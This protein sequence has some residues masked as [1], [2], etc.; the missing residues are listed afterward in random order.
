MQVP[1]TP[2]RERESDPFCGP[3]QSPIES[4]PNIFT[5]GSNIAV[6]PYK[7]R[8]S[9]P[10][11]W[12]EAS[13]PKAKAPRRSVKNELSPRSEDVKNAVHES[14][15]IVHAN[16][17]HRIEE[18]M[19]GMVETRPPLA[20]RRSAPHLLL[21]GINLNMRS[22]SLRVTKLRDLL[23]LVINE[24]LHVGG[25]PDFTLSEV[26]ELGER[27][28]V[29][30]RSSNGEIFS[31]TIVWSVD[32]ALPETLL[33]DDK[34]LAKLIS[35][36]F[37]NAVKFTNS[38]MITV[39]AKVG[40]NVG[41]VFITV[42][43]T[44]PGIPEAFLPKLFTPFAREDASI[45][46]SKD[47][48]GLGLLVAKGL[49]RKMGGDLICVRSS[50]SGPDHGSEF[51]ISIPVT[52]SKL[53]N[54]PVA[55]TASIPTPPDGG[56]PSRLSTTSTS[57]SSGLEQSM[58]SPSIRRPSQPIQQPSPS[59][60]EG[61]SSQTST[62]VR[63]VSTAKF[64]RPSINADAYDEKLGQKH[65]LTFLV[66][67]DN[68]INRRVLVSMLKR[69]GYQHIYEAC[70]GKEAVRVMQDVLASQTSKTSSRSSDCRKRQAEDQLG[71]CACK[72]TKPV[73]VVLM[74]LWMPEM[75]GYE[76]TSKILRLVDEYQLQALQKQPNCQANNLLLPLPTVLAVSADVT[77]EALGRASKV[78]IKGYMTK[79]YKL[80]DLE[81]L[82]VEFC[83]EATIPN[84]DR[85]NIL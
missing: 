35:C 32:E 48:L 11:D 13:T 61:I 7:R 65:P 68:M 5:E 80:S 66:A 10:A 19:A 57:S 20:V 83:G 85:T 38:G 53:S 31:K 55:C 26:T 24:S 21:E 28:E 15:Q 79:P 4:L 47:G 75:D 14:E 2:Q 56:D 51:E 78:G 33:V 3:V 77:D 36:V 44:G 64:I 25:R 30:T 63:S 42:R 71:D 46:R 27:I 17:S 29:R 52:Q 58:L 45:T 72:R 54:K 18:A 9:N 34:D 59:L 74:D 60:T 82:I 84:L 22:P 73:D 43:D 8:R 81:R 6:N 37:L 50:T 67:E 62:P 41:E 76:A 16:P 23:R 1:K 12:N 69:L 39:S 49:A 40:P 70:N